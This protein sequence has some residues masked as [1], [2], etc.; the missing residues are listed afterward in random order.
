MLFMKVPGK[1]Y[2][3]IVL[4]YIVG[5]IGNNERTITGSRPEIL[6]VAACLL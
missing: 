2:E 5:I 6:A 1:F 4:L 3:G